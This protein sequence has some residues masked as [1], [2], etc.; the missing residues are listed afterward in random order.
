MDAAL[1]S[2]AA[3]RRLL[4]DLSVPQRLSEVGVIEADIPNLVDELMTF[5]AIPMALQNPRDVGPQEAAEI[6][7][8]AL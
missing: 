7:R 2:V 6:F 1:K 5:Q 3:V 8:R 4:S